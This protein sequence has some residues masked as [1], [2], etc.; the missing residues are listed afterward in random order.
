MAKVTYG[1]NIV[2]ARN[3][4]GSVV[5]TRNRGG[6]IIRNKVTPHNPKSTAQQTIRT[7]LTSIRKR[8]SYTL[9]DAQRAAWS[10]LQTQLTLS[11]VFHQAKSL[12]GDLWY[13]KLNLNLSLI[14]K[15]IID[16]PPGSIVAL[17]PNDIAA[18][19]ATYSPRALSLTPA[20]A[21]DSS[22][23]ALVSAT[24]LFPASRYSP[25]GKLRNIATFPG[26]SAGPFD[27]S[28]Q[29][30]TKFGSLIPSGV[31]LATLEYINNATGARSGALLQRMTWPGAPDQMLQTTI[32]I[33]ST[34]ILSLYTSPVVIVAA[35]GSGYMIS[36]IRVTVR[37]HY[38][39]TAYSLPSTPNICFLWTTSYLAYA[40]A[41][42]FTGLLNATSDQILQSPV[43]ANPVDPSSYFDN[44][45]LHFTIANGNPTLGNGTLTV[46]LDYSIDAIT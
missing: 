9:T 19:T 17:S 16:T 34:A 21:L 30:A 42:V 25:N 31:I 12:T 5:Y 28:T 7:A 43:S 39:G 10:S 15:P 14:G 29:W 22:H 20:T 4:C 13:C 38:G 36:P 46:T 44:Q 1:P 11:D 6:Q 45:P 40:T 2:D 18:W 32:E 8:W 27:F 23:T 33:N 26:P 24:K 3:K 35:P 37:Y 41:G